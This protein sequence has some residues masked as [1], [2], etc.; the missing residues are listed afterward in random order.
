MAEATGGQPKSALEEARELLGQKQPGE[1]ARVL[2]EY[3]AGEPGTAE[4]QMLLGVAAAQ[5]G[6]SRGAIEAFEQAVARDPNHAAA[7]FNLC[8]VYRQVG[9][10]RDA[11]ASC[12]RALELRPEYP[13]ASSAA[14]ELRRQVQEMAPPP[15]PRAPT[16]PA[17]PPGSGYGYPAAPGYGGPAAADAYRAPVSRPLGISIL[18]VLYDIGA[19]FMVI[20]GILMLVGAG[21]VG[22]MGA[23]GAGRASAPNT[24]G[25]IAAGGLIAAIA[26]FTLLLGLA[27]LVIGHFLWKGVSWARW[28]F[29]VIL[30][31][32]V[33]RALAG[34]RNS[35]VVS[36]LSIVLGVLFLIV[37]NTQAAKEYCTQ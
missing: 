23:T 30:V 36:G 14:A 18:V 28:A 21:A 9:R 31:L 6:D 34:L 29:M 3:L 12:E 35:P 10:L 24:A 20:G 13:A 22:I 7:H 2:R 33:L 26:I 19:I 37:L 25:A 16:A 15:E 5:S 17:P 4:E 8:Q 1:A 27:I 32:D 11:L